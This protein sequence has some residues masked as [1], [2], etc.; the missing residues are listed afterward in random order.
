MVRRRFLITGG[1]SGI[2][3]AIADTL[4]ET[5]HDVVGLARQGDET[6]PGELRAVDLADAAALDRACAAAAAERFDGLVNNVGS[7][8]PAPLGAVALASLEAAM[9]LNLGSAVAVTQAVLPAMR[10]QGWGRIV[11]IAS[12]SALGVPERTSYVAAKAAL[13]G[14]TRT[15]AL[16]LATSG[17]TVNAV[18]PGPGRTP[19]YVATNPPGSA[20]EARHLA[21][22]PMKRLGTPAEIAAAVCFLLS[23]AASFVTGQTLF[24]DGGASIGK[25]MS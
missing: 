23:E 9:R 24:V 6:F 22:V 21:S 3:R 7:V 11:N 5:G 25:A 8:H 14:V 17:I 19:L 2:G 12:V 10:A 16:E 20:G 1:R 18:A 4:A 13:I 15:W